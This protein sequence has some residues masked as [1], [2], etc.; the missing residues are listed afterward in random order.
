MIDLITKVGFLFYPLCFLS[1]LASIIILE[2]LFYFIRLPKVQ[3]STFYLEIS[4]LLDKN[5]EIA[6]NLR[7]ELI[8]VKLIEYQNILQNGLYSLKMIAIITPMIG[9]LGTV[10][11]M[12]KSFKVISKLDSAVVPSMIADGLFNAMLTTAYGLA[13]A[14]ISLFFTFIYL[15]I[16]EKYLSNIQKLANIKSFKLAKININD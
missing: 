13:I 15:R 7:D 8:E 5:S 6:K 11:G 9:L 10:I 2:R 12:I 3:N 14:I 4:K 1:L 16:S